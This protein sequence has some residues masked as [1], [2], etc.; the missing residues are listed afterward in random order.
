MVKNP[1]V[2]A[3]DARDT[4]SIPGSGRSPGDTATHSCGFLPRKFHRQRSLVGHS[5]WAGKESDTT[6]HASRPQM[7]RDVRD[8]GKAHY[9]PK[10]K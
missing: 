2:K 9:F 6:D 1:P 7:E 4:S 5:A 8:S 10:T 3:G